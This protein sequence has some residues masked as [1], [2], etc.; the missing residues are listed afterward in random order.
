MGLAPAEALQAAMKIAHGGL[1]PG[2]PI[3]RWRADVAFMVSGLALCLVGAPQ[4]YAWVVHHVSHSLIT[5][6]VA[7]HL[8]AN[9]CANFLTGVGA[10]SARG[11]LD[12]KLGRALYAVL[13]SH[14]LLAMVVVLTHSVYSNIVML[15]AVGVS[16]VYGLMVAIVAHVVMRPRIAVVGPFETIPEHLPP[17]VERIADPS[18]DLRP[19]DLVLTA[20]ADQLPAEWTRA[21]SRVMLAGKPVRH[22]AA[23]LEETRGLVSLDHFEVDQ[24]TAGGLASYQAGKRALDLAIAIVAVPFAAPLVL[25]ASL[26]ILMTM[27]RPVLFVQPRVGLGGRSFRIFKLRT[28]TLEAETAPQTVTRVGQWLRLSRVDELPQLWNV[29]IGDMS[30]I[31]PRPEW[32]VLAERYVAQLP[33]YAYRHL[34]RPGITGWAQVRSGYAGDLQETRLKVAYDLFYLKHFSFA[35]DLQVLLRTVFTLLFARG[36]R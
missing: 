9:G 19:Y 16:I 5:R 12:E 36:A 11:R 28:M 14:G 22:C 24:L 26:A 21:I 34:V 33:A 6:P 27:G 31:G 32:T 1:A 13:V 8:M 23:F 4:F 25:I 3:R 20:S 18:L 30:F 10:W 35:L 29:L 7:L 17:H 15:T 2:G